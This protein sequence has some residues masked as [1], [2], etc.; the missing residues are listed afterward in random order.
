MDAQCVL[1]HI[2]RNLSIGEKFGSSDACKAFAHDLMRA[3]LD[4]PEWASS[5]YLGPATDRLF[6]KH[7][8]IGPDR[9][10]EEKRAANQF[11]TQ[12]LDQIRACAENAEDPVFA[13]LKLSILGNYLDFAALPGQEIKYTEITCPA[14]GGS[15]NSGGLAAIRVDV[16][17][18]APAYSGDP[19]L[20]PGLMKYRRIQICPTCGGSGKMIKDKCPSCGGTGRTRKKRT[21]TVKGAA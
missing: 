16:L 12:R 21:V 20:L 10:R 1:C 17:S 11:V 19:F 13:G 4:A 9:Y 6:E 3:H 5:P 8:G 15:G 18:G 7:F 2:S 14:C